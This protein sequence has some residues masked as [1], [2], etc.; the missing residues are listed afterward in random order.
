MKTAIIRGFLLVFFALINNSCAVGQISSAEALLFAKDLDCGY[1]YKTIDIVYTDIDKKSGYT[2]RCN[3]TG[4]KTRDKDNTISIPF[5]E[6]EKVEDLKV[7]VQNKKGNFVKL[8]E[9][10]EHALVSS[11]FYDGVK[12]KS[13]IIEGSTF[14]YDFN[15]SY[16][17]RCEDLM[18]FDNVQLNYGDCALEI[19][20]HIY[21]PE[22]YKFLYDLCG[23][24][25]TLKSFEVSQKKVDGFTVYTFSSK[26]KHNLEYKV[27]G[28]D[29]SG[30]PIY[31]RPKTPLFR[32]CLLPPGATNGF[33]RI[34]DY[35]N[36]LMKSQSEL[37]EKSMEEIM[38]WSSDLTD[39][40]EIVECIFD[41]IKE[42][43]SYVA[44]ENGIGAVR[45]RNVNDIL[46]KK[47]GDCKDMANLIVQALK[48][49]GIEAHMAISSTI[50]HSRDMD[51]PS[52]FSADH[53]IA[54]AEINGK[55]LYLDA[56]EDYNEYGFPSRQIQNRNVFIVDE[57]QGKLVKVPVVPNS[58]NKAQFEANLIKQGDA[59]NGTFNYQLQGLSKL[60]L[61]TYV[62]QNAQKDINQTIEHSLEQYFKNID[63][64]NISYKTTDS[65]LLVSGKITATNVFLEVGDVNYLSQ[66]ILMYPHTYQ[67]ILEENEELYFPHA[68]NNQ[69]TFRIDVGKE[70]ILAKNYAQEHKYDE[71]TFTYKVDV[72]NSSEI[73]IDYSISTVSNLITA[74]NSSNYNEI[75]SSIE[76]TFSKKIKY[77]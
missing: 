11:S 10:R 18:F 76:H 55:Y 14:S 69:F 40:N 57:Q 4:T 28:K 73:L 75:N 72:Q 23:D 60:S 27:T 15:Y 48:L 56:T 44:F 35:Y 66:N 52:L 74:E 54:V 19:N 63:L 62:K 20:H 46:L 24:T 1:V 26:P 30:H 50:S 38:Q 7:N 45:P 77:E 2:K 43:I 21:V 61:Y 22:N 51:F 64:S 8:K 53:C 3:Y 5:T 9:F 39:K 12:A 47:Q 37:N 68:L 36:D 6:L 41:S 70:A 34:N 49:H 71:C 29:I 31:Y 17:K 32:I 33:A 13:F 42:K 58:E 67:P 59:V 25:S 16:T 65:L